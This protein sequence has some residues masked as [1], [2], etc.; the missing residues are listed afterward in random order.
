MGWAL[1]ILFVLRQPVA[2]L[3]T[4]SAISTGLLLLIIFQSNNL[5]QVGKQGLIHIFRGTIL[6]LIS[7][8]LGLGFFL[9]IK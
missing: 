7:Y 2:V 9:W 5:F 8:Y 4:V 3:I 6:I 1:M